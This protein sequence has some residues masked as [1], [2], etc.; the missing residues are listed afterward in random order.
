MFS[1]YFQPSLIIFFYDTTQV[2]LLR[3]L[4]CNE[5][6]LL[7]CTK[8]HN[9]NLY[10]L[11]KPSAFFKIYASCKRIKTLFSKKN[12]FEFFDQ[13]QA[14]NFSIKFFVQCNLSE[15]KITENREK[16][17]FSKINFFKI[18]KKLEIYDQ[19]QAKKVS[20]KFF[21]G[22]FISEIKIES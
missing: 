1:R 15:I 7:N 12:F 22:C 13:F 16:N 8:I 19:F 5:I 2:S 9:I 14:K 21:R 20:C 4:Q 6:K 3:P 11:L 17:F 18:K 10:M